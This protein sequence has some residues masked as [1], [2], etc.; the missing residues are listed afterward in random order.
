MAKKG[1]KSICFKNT[2]KLKKS[3]QALKILI[4]LKSLG[5]LKNLDKN[6]AAANS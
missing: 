1:G 3:S 5:N 4:T 6:L 2:K